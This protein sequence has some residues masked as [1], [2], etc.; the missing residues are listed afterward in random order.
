MTL[1][2]RARQAIIDGNYFEFRDEFLGR[3]YAGAAAK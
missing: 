2:E 3:Y 1:V